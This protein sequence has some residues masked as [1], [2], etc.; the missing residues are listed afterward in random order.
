MHHRLNADVTKK[1]HTWASESA[2]TVNEKMLPT[3]RIDQVI[4]FMLN[5]NTD[6]PLRLDDSDR[7]YLIIKTDAEPHADGA[8]YYDKLYGVNNVGGI[9]DNSAALGAILFELMHRDLGNYSIEH[10][11]PFTAAKA[12]TIAAG[13]GEVARWMIENRGT[14][15]LSWRVVRLAEIIEGMPRYMQSRGVMKAVTEA[16][17]EH[18]NG[19]P[20]PDQI[21]PDGM[22]GDKIAVWL[23]GVVNDP[24]APLRNSD[25][26]A[27]YREDRRHDH[28]HVPDPWE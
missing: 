2:I 7:R 25:V 9:L 23:I 27:M 26:L 18:F 17:R 12:E 16:L 28:K 14:P 10:P 1:L 21:R 19:K 4:A 3:F 24:A 22:R 5:T 20:W 13:A 6:D 8:V 15:P 11:A